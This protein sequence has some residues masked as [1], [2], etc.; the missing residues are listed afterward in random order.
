MTSKP[1]KFAS[2]FFTG[3]EISLKD[4]RGVVKMNHCGNCLIE[5]DE[6]ALF[7]SVE[8]ANEWYESLEESNYDYGE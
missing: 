2:K 1:V 6:E 5:I 7:C 8:C 4:V 3:L